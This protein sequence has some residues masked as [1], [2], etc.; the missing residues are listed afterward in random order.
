[1]K[2]QLLKMVVI[3]LCLVSIGSSQLQT[4]FA[5]KED[6]PRVYATPSEDF[7]S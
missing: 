1:M 3:A 2:K 4:S 6:V 5:G 7:P